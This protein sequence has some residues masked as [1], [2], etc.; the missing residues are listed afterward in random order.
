[1]IH[2]TPAT[3]F[4]GITRSALDREDERVAIYARDRGRCQTCG[5][6]VAWGDFELAHGIAATKCNYRKYGAE[7]VD[8]ALNKH[9]THRGRCNDA[10]N[11]AGDP[12]KCEALIDEIFAAKDAKEQ[13]A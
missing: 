2:P 8:H 7:I 9:L 1:M 11:I 5:E 12:G 4:D 10:Q 13:E 3:K 6:P